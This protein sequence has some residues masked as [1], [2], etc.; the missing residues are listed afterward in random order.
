MMFIF[1]SPQ[2]GKLV[3][4]DNTFCVRGTQNVFAIG[5]VVLGHPELTPVAI[6]DGELLSEALFGL[7]EVPAA[8]WHAAASKL[9]GGRNKLVP[10]TVFTPHEYSSV[11]MSEEV[12]TDLCDF[13]LFVRWLLRNLVLIM[14]KFIC[15]SGLH[16][17]FHLLIA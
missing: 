6:R 4:D 13:F 9:I 17:S 3:V 15:S 2:Y 11:G 12:K 16:W 1:Q 10:T 7:K 14:L 5:D 8:N